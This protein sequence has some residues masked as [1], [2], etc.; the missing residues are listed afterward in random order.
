MQTPKKIQNANSKKLNNANSTKNTK[1]K[2]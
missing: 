1:E 2:N